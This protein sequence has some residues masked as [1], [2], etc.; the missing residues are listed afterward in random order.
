MN[1]LLWLRGFFVVGEVTKSV[2]AVV[3]NLEL[4]LS[5]LLVSPKKLWLLLVTSSGGVR[6]SSNS[7]ESNAKL[8][9]FELIDLIVNGLNLRFYAYLLLV[10][11]L[12]QFKGL[13]AWR[14]ELFFLTRLRKETGVVNS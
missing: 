7:R 2:G 5:D 13:L 6:R 14:S 9:F 12:L 10:L 11:Q 8:K 1:C 4:I 3:T